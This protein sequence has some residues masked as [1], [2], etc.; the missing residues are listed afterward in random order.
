MKEA[1]KSSDQK[2][3]ESD[4]ESFKQLLGPFV[5]AAETTRMPMVFTNAKTPENLIVFANASF[6]ELSGYE[7]KEVLGESLD[8]LLARGMDPEAYKQ[9]AAA[10]A[11]PTK[12]ESE[13]HYRRK[14][15]SEFWGS[16]FISPC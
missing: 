6:L 16:V 9:L 8:E 11:D 12:K 3:A 5:V 15:D 10:F 13:I 7:S 14:D 2:I 4:I 1:N